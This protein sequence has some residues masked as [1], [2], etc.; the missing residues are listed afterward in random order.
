MKGRIFIVV[1]LVAAAA[2]A[3]RWVNRAVHVNP[4]GAQREETRQTFRLDAGA[5]VEVS[6]INGTV[7]VTTADTDAAEVHII[8]TASS[9]DDLEYGRINV[10][11]SPSS[12]VVRGEGQGGR[13]L[14]HRL[15]NGGGQVRQEVTLVLPRRVELSA[16][17]VNGAVQVGAVEGPVEVSHVNGR[18]EVAQS[19]GHVAVSHINGGVKFGISQLGEEGMEVEHVNGNVEIRLSQLVNADVEAQHHNGSLTL[20]VPNVTM[21]ERMNRSYARARFGTGGTPVQIN[22]VNGNVRFESDAGAATTTL[23]MSDTEGDELPPPPPAPP[24]PPAP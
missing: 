7:T 10:E 23:S 14:W 16:E 4:N 17:H 18:V 2:F 22:H 3:G 19:A 6:Q 9:P 15:W 20:N 13:G 11:T 5:R 1:V 21:Q 8:R 24:A 12:L